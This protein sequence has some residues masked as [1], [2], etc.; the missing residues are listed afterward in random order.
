MVEGYAVIGYN[1][2]AQCLMA[3]S[4]TLDIAYLFKLLAKAKSKEKLT[5]GY[6]GFDFP[7]CSLCAIIRY[8]SYNSYLFNT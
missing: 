5:H 3:I 7:Q 1:L 2:K 8:R 6:H 4:S